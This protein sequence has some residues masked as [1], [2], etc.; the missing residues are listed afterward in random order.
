MGTRGIQKRK[1][2]VVVS[3]KM[4]KTI[5]V[6]VERLVPHPVYQKYVKRR[7]R[8]KAHDEKNEY[9]IGDRVE[10]IETR[11]LSKDKRW[12]VNRLIDRPVVR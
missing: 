10:I 5:V 6:Q 2:G 12:R 11:P 3:D 4:D 1:V 8:I 7:N 9:Q